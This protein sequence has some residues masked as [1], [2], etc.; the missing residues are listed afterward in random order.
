MDAT[1]LRKYLAARPALKTLDLDTELT[2]PLAVALEEALQK[3]SSLTALRLSGGINETA[4]EALGRAIRSAPQL[5]YVRLQ[6]LEMRFDESAPVKIPGMPES[7][8][9]DHPPVFLG[10]HSNHFAL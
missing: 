8:T 1:G 4:T 7:P 3:N 2:E 9:K 10:T 6:E 5:R